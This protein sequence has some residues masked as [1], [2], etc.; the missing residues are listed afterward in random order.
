MVN[1]GNKAGYCQ[2][3]LLLEVKV[4]EGRISNEEPRVAL[5]DAPSPRPHTAG[6]VP[7]PALTE[8]RGFPCRNA[9]IDRYH[10][11]ALRQARGGSQG[12]R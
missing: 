10:T 7:M 6:Q 8:R 1:L 9:L 2:L 12:P 4:Q 11:F 5:T 3:G